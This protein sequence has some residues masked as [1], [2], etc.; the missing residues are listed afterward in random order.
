[1]KARPGAPRPDLAYGNVLRQLAP[2][3]RAHDAAGILVRRAFHEDEPVVFAEAL[4][5]APVNPIRIAATHDPV[6][7]AH[8]EEGQVGKAPEAAI[9]DDDVAPSKDA[10]QQSEEACLAR[11]PLAVGG[12]QERAAA[13][14]E[15]AD[16]ANER[17]AA[18]GFL[19]AGLGHSCWLS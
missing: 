13:Q 12:A 17:K 19:G 5:F 14:A 7:S 10:A 8:G 1:M 2:K 6:G 3:A 16:D 18:T 15:D 9:G 4:A 11:F